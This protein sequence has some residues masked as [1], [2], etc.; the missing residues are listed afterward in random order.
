MLAE[1]GRYV[2]Y[3]PWPFVIDTAAGEGMF[4]GTVDGQRLFDWAGY[5]GSKL[6][7]HNHPRLR[8]PAYLARLADAANNKLANPD[9]LTPQ[10]L[11]YYRLCHGLA[12]S[13]MQ[14][15][16]LEFYALNSG[17][18]AV[19]NM[20]KYLVSLHNRKRTRS[21]GEPRRFVSFDR[22]FH[23]RT[24]YTL[25]VTQTADPVA[26]RDFHGLV[27]VRDLPL[28]FPAIDSDARDSENEARTAA[29]LAAVEAVL[30]QSAGEVVAI[31]VEPL[32]GAGGQRVASAE[33]FRGLSALAHRYDTYLAFDEV[34]T[35]AGATGTV[36]AIEQFELPHPPQAI[37]VGK[38]F[39]LGGV[40][41]RQSLP[42]VGVLD[43]TWGGNLADMVR[44]VHEWQIV[45]DEHLVARAAA[46][47]RYLA[48]ALR[49]L[50]ARF[51]GKVRNIRG[52]GL[53]QG[54]SLATPAARDRLV[55]HAL[56]R[57]DLLLLGAGADSVRLRPNLSVTTA[58]I[59]QLTGHLAE[60]LAEN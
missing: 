34:Q 57:Q 24:V 38:K 40:Y 35:S 4:L 42:D 19:E 60:G 12:P 9:F 50:Q 6:I 10:C 28:P 53:Y 49:G 43:S 31:V 36:F 7:G 5:Y 45:E 52:L 39:G 41:M 29:A 58:D 51:P 20:L 17:A 32:Q 54:F 55:E 2:R 3:E 22:A 1:M 13:A 30:R 14:S 48:D 46:N 44:F 27:A 47:G 59:D 21:P 56:Q 15:A 37:A 8:E 18:E 33:F 11:D 25:N 16:D 26:T 23:G